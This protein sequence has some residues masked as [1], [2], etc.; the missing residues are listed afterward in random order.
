LKRL[1]VIVVSL[2]LA[3]ALLFGSTIVDQA[4]VAH[5]AAYSGPG[6]A[7]RTAAINAIKH[8]VTEVDLYVHIVNNQAIVSPQLEHTITAAQY[9]DVLQL[10]NEYN[11][12]PLSAKQ[13]SKNYQSVSRSPNIVRHSDY[14]SWWD[15]FSTCMSWPVNAIISVVGNVF[16]AFGTLAAG[17]YA[18]LGVTVPAWALALGVAG[19]F[20]FLGA[21]AFCTGYANAWLWYDLT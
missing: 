4:N 3:V 2:L 10:A 13:D 21:T 17:I 9:N 12:L 6:S 16:M 7:Q 5:A 1:S 15:A 11:A 19:A 14:S 18:L 20:L 8:L